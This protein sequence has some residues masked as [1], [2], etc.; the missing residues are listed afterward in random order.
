VSTKTSAGAVTKNIQ[1]SYDAFGKRIAKLID[2]DGA[3]A[4]APTT[5]RLIY[6][7]NNIVLS[8]DGNN[9]QTHRYLHSPG[10][11]QILADEVSTTNVLWT[12]SDHQGTVRDVVNNAGTVV[13]HLRYDSFGKVTGQTS[14]TVSFRYGFTGRE[15]DTETGLNYYRARYQDP[16]TGQFVSQDP[17]GFGGGDSNIYRYVGNSPTNRID[18]SGQFKIEFRYRFAPLNVANHADIVVTDEVVMNSNG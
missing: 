1:Y 17:L 4:T 8:F 5:E 3:G 10:V 15:N 9:A 12:L 7:G 11:D 6:D 14:T 18:P 2:A 13:N 16:S